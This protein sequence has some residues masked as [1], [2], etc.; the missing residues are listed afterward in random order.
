MKCPRCSS[1]ELSW[2]TGGKLWCNSCGICK[3]D[4]DKGIKELKAHIHGYVRDDD[5]VGRI[6]VLI[7]KTIQG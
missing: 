7:D 6:M 1:Q 3:E 5:K 4:F 2:G